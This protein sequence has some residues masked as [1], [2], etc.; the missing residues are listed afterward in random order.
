M[1]TSVIKT[2]F[3]AGEL[4]PTLF[5]RV[6]LSK[7]ASGAAE[8][9]NFYV[10]YRGGIT[11]RPGTRFV[12]ET[13]SSG[14]VRLVEF[15][16][17]AT[18]TY[19]I[20]FGHR[21]MRLIQNGGLVVEDARPATYD[22]T[23]F[24]VGTA[25]W[26]AGDWLFAQYSD[27]TSGILKITDV[28]SIG[29]ALTA[30]N[31]N[32]TVITNATPSLTLSRI[33]KLNTPYTDTQIPDMRFSQSA[34]VMTITHQD[35]P[36]RDL[37][38]L[39]NTDWTLSRI[40]F[41]SKLPPPNNVRVQ[42]SDDDGKACYG[43]TVTSVTNSGEESRAADPGIIKQVVNISATEGSMLVRWDP[44]P[45]ADYYNVYRTTITTSTDFK[46][47][48]GANPTDV[49]IP[50]GAQYGFVGTAFG[51]EFVDPNIVPDF[52]ATPPKGSNPFADG[53]IKSLTVDNQGDGYGPGAY[54]VIASAPSGS[55][56]IGRPVVQNGKLTAVYIEA[57]GQNYT[58]PVTFTVLGGTTPTTQATFTY[59]IGPNSGNFP[60]C[61]TYFQQRKVFAASYNKPATIWGSRPGAFNNFDVSIPT[62]DGDAFEFGL[63]SQQVNY[64]KHLVQMPNGLIALTA[65]GAWQLNGGG[66]NAPL[67][68][69]NAVATPQAFIG[70][71][72]VPP[73]LINY[74]L[75]YAQA[76]GGNVRSLAY[77]FVA[78]AYTGQD[79]SILSSHMF[80][81]GRYIS[82]WAY[83]EEPY[84]VIW[85][86]RND[87]AGLAFTYLKDQEIY[88]WTRTGTQGEYLSAGRVQ[89]GQVDVVYYVVR[90][91]INQRVVQCIEQ[92]VTQKLATVEDGWYVDCGLD[93]PQSTY[94]LAV[95]LT[96]S[97]GNVHLRAAGGVGF[98]S[99]MVGMVFR[100]AGARGLVT[101]LDPDGR[102]AITLDRPV[103][104][105]TPPVGPNRR[106]RRLMPKDWTLSRPT[107]TVKGLDHLEGQTVAIFA[108][109]NVKP[110]AVVSGGQVELSA[111]ASKITVGLPYTARARTLPL[112][113]GQAT[114]QGKRK[115]V[116]AVAVKVKDTKGLL[117]GPDY[118][119]LFEVKNRK[120]NLQFGEAAPLE[121]GEIWELLPGDY[122]PY[123]E[124]CFASDDPL[125]ASV[126]A[127]TFEV[128]IGDV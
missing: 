125:P 31:Q 10:D 23:Y 116:V 46:D 80:D 122:T 2:A 78:N 85:C 72:D 88:A 66:D 40:Q 1:P 121:T 105:F 115:S 39:G 97:S 112:E 126:L 32:N 76:K 118:D 110:R 107:T 53:F 99:D 34:D 93:Y 117:I 100:G 26:V 41:T 91:N 20:E 35:H 54:K 65:S 63:V 43:Y 51:I 16:F 82:S 75:V 25:D 60:R 90:R 87:G 14:N 21:Y 96:G 79:L 45:E 92:Q 13:F 119:R 84:K 18:Q 28:A 89:E 48:G 17:S 123:G 47:T 58:D 42:A 37:K 15:Q 109:G 61:S 6:D 44:E 38:R 104:E 24:F 71:S 11:K 62:N 33:F 64:I 81:N 111:P 70:A 8:L 98:T 106:P 95:N 5:G 30:R 128:N 103:T 83:A 77:N 127:V 59:T 9:Y 36:P 68:A 27:G 69:T 94:D 56:F 86:T 49:D 22:G 12:A 73:L 57:P 114:V 120:D 108:D 50:S 19:M 55:G 101:A 102:L 7:Y 74:D 124:V 3:T 4:S 113:S 29:S 67:T 52:V